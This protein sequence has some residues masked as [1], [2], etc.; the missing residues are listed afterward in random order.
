[1]TEAPSWEVLCG[2]AAEVLRGREESSVDCCVTS[3][4]YYGLR[5]YGT[6]E[7]VGGDADCAHRPKSLG[8]GSYAR[9][10][11]ASL[12]SG[13][14][15]RGA[16]NRA[17]VAGAPHRGAAPERECRCGAVLEDKQI[18]L[19]PSPGEFVTA[20]VDVFR[21]VRRVLKPTGS[22]WLNLGDSYA[23]APPG[24][25]RASETSGLT[26]PARQATQGSAAAARRPNRRPRTWEGIKPKDLLLIP[27]MTALALR[28]DGWWLR[29]EVIW[30][31]PNPMPESVQ[32]RC[33]RSHEQ[34]FHL[35]KS[36]R[37]LYDAQ[38]IAEPTVGPERS[39]DFVRPERM[40]GKANGSSRPYESS[41]TR[42]RRDVWSLNSEPSPE[43]HYAVMPSRLVE[44]CVLATCP[45]GGVVLDPFAGLGTVGLVA[46]R[47]GR[48]FLGVELSPKYAA[49]ARARVGT[50][51]SPLFDPAQ[52]A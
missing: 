24:G 21:E 47:L 19:E 4:P 48:S 10:D 52:V 30:A 9:E 32:D 18:G 2:D 49:L 40:G 27:A 3:P 35:T 7:W 37:Y 31:K 28:E 33:T 26:N 42:N 16:A 45:A 13:D 17:H 20:L 5:D 23:S 50:A 44:P 36:A 11:G 6:G 46:V 12:Y 39:N 15:L 1:M 41:G 34:L 8:R 29:Q 22:L 43:E 14:G 38:A 25:S 51:T